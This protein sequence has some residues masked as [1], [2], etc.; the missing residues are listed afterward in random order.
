MLKGFQKSSQK[1]HHHLKVGLFL[2]FKYFSYL[3]CFFLRAHTANKKH[4]KLQKF[5]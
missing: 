1:C 2:N 5:C 3:L 4:V